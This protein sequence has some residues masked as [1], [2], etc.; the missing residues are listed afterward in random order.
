MNKK[1]TVHHD[2]NEE[3]KNHKLTIRDKICVLLGK[4]EEMEQ[5]ELVE[6]VVSGVSAMLGDGTPGKDKVSSAKANAYHWIQEDLIKLLEEDGDSKP[7]V[8][9]KGEK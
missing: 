1:T 3:E 4:Y 6:T 9:R 7:E 8:E 5:Q 2:S